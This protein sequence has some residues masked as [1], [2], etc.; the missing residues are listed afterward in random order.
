MVAT[1]EIAAHDPPASRHEAGRHGAWHVKDGDVLACARC[2]GSHEVF[3]LD[4]VPR[5][6]VVRCGSSTLPV[7]IENERIPDAPPR[8]EF[9]DLVE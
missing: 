3:T 9:S 5:L 4:G 2:G 7:G 1:E 6:Q 8:A